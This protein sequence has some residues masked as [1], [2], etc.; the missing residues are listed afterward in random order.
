M[1]YCPLIDDE[2]KE[3]RCMWWT[4]AKYGGTCAITKIARDVGDLEGW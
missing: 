4:K 1:S 3:H 2:C